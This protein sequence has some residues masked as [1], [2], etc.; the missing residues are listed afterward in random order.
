[1]AGYD[2]DSSRAR[3]HLRLHL[4]L[5][6]VPVARACC[7][8]T[9]RRSA[10]GP[11]SAI[12]TISTAAW[13]ACATSTSRG[14][15]GADP[16]SSSSTDG[17]SG[18]VRRAACPSG[19]ARRAPAPRE[20]AV[21]CGSGN[22]AMRASA[23]TRACTTGPTVVIRPNGAHA[24]RRRPCADAAFAHR[25]APHRRRLCY[26]TTPAASPRA[27]PSSNTLTRRR[28]R[29]GLPVVDNHRSII[30]RTDLRP[31]PLSRRL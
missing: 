9:A 8:S 7:A 10:H 29:A 2:L 18:A 12:G 1:M 21:S 14:A 15:E 26:S 30:D 19:M 13:G 11:A 22:Q 23:C 3:V 24:P 28:A 25:A 31:L 16:L 17:P 20:P 4:I 6:I 5:T 27:A